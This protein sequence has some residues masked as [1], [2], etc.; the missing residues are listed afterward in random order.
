MVDEVNTNLKS[1]AVM[2]FKGKSCNFPLLNFTFYLLS[3]RI[4]LDKDFLF[5]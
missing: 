3:V 1:P 5:N 2:Q 4:P